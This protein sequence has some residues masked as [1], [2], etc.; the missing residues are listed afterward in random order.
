MLKSILLLFTNDPTKDEKL[1]GF[2]ITIPVSFP[3]GKCAL[4]M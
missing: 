2:F 3:D 1:V 4:P